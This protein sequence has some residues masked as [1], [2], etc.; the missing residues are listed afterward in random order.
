MISAIYHVDAA[1]APISNARPLLILDADEV[2]LRFADGFDKFLRARALYLDFSSYRL[3][4]NVRRLDDNT[5]ALDIEVTALLDEFRTEL[6]ALEP[7]EGAVEMLEALS[8]ELDAV[9]LS[10]VSGAQA[11]A[12]RRNLDSLGFRY[13]LIINSGSKGQA[14]RRLAD[15]AG[16]PVFFIDDI[17]QHHGSVAEQAPDVLRI[18]F[19]GDDRL[20]PLMPDSPHAHFRAGSWR[21]VDAFIRQHLKS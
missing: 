9:V 1:A 5:A 20:K 11:P 3:H 12:R 2:L 16:R 4:G 19:I 8:P 14:V 21:D 7:M 13:P 6:D 10:N 18:H 15:R 17:S